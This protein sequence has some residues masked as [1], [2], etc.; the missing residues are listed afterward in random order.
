MNILAELAHGATII[1]PN[2]RLSHQLLRDFMRLSAS[3]VH[4]KPRCMPYTAFLRDCFRQAQHRYAQRAHP[5]LLNAH[6]E[7]LL[8]REVI[9]K[10]SHYPITD[11]LIHAVHEAWV[12]CQL[13]CIDVNAAAFSHTKQTQQFQQWH[14]AFQHQLSSLD[15]ITEAQL[16]PYLQGFPSYGPAGTGHIVWVAFDDFTPQ[17]RRLQVLLE[18]QGMTHSFDEQPTH[19]N[20]ATV[21]Q[22]LDT[23]DEIHQL[24]KWLKAQLAADV[25]RI[26]VVVP[27]LHQQSQILQRYLNR[28]L[29][30]SQL[31]FSIGKSLS[32][33][34]LVAHALHWLSLDKITLSHHQIRLLLHSPYLHGACSE[35][36]ERA[37]LLEACSLLQEAT[38]PYATLC[39]ALSQKAPKLTEL[40][41]TL[42]DYPTQATPAEWATHFKTRLTAFQFPGDYPLNSAAYQ[43]AE[44]LHALL[45]D[46]WGLGVVQPL[47]TE[48][49]ALQAL[50]DMAKMTVFQVRKTPSPIQVLG[51]LEASGCEFDAMWVMGLTDQCLPKKVKLSPFIPMSIQ[52]AHHMPHA[53]PEREVQLATQLLMRLTQGSRQ[54][55]F[56]FPQ[57][58]GDTPNLPSPL[59][60]GLSVYTPQSEA[61][62]VNP[63][64]LVEYMESYTH[65][66]TENEALSGGTALLAHVAQCP[67]RAFAA[68]RLRLKAG[69]K[70]STGLN[71]A[72]RGQVVHQ[73]LEMI[74]RTLGSQEALRQ[75]TPSDLD[76]LMD[77]AIDGALAPIAQRRVDSFPPLIQSL[78]RHRLKTLAHAA[79]DW[80]QQRAPFVV[81]SVEEAFTFHLAGLDLKVRV[82]RLDR[83][84]DGSSWV[85]DYK[86]SLPAHKPWDEERPEAPQLL[87]YALL[88]PDISTLLYLQLK[89]GKL[90]CS[91][92][93]QEKQSMKGIGTLKK[94]E[95]W[96]KKRAEWHQRLTALAMTFR[97][98]HCTPTPQRVS[99]CLT[100]EYKNLCRV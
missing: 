40:L 25:G 82:D 30:T 88:D 3:A 12:R 70:Q 16:V 72:E 41:A 59:I 37:T 93:S 66:L 49:S 20:C 69:L 92:L 33:Y 32:D 48:A 90:T 46:F 19:L 67:F 55:I 29:P 73:V 14:L 54:S 75:K 4:D 100:C 79:L 81:E 23:Q 60:A 6:Q 91:G 96:S 21:Y 63:S 15:A 68:H 18:S 80:D 74:W 36:S 99:T 50:R 89:A 7:R 9:G 52:R 34:P 17:Q 84:A 42:S 31:E 24:V 95:T 97:E 27:D 22:A 53:L 71:D 1:T 65:P 61:L 39:Q 77:K 2:N 85:I 38:V 62:P 5:V 58:S 86:S 64:P 26:A 44:R 57:F 45:D 47:M 8:W 83:V 56:S 98:G 10:E 51:L 78:E 11:G 43:Y 76:A 94:E 13:W 35:F 87:L 28:S